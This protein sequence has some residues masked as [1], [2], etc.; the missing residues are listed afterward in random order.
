MKIVD[1]N[2]I[3]EWQ[4]W[5]KGENQI[6]RVKYYVEVK[7]SFL[8]ETHG[9]KLYID[10]KIIF[11]DENNFFSVGLYFEVHFKFGSEKN[12]HKKHIYLSIVEDFFSSCKFLYNWVVYIFT[13]WFI[14]FEIF[15]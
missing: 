6:L 7:I 8:R 11:W 14:F 13:E 10:V 15:I 1:L 3:L 5:V 9:W 4:L 12:W 2:Y